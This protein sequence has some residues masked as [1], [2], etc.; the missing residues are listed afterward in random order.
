[1]TLTRSAYATPEHWE[2]CVSPDGKIY[3]RHRHL[4]ETPCC[5]YSSLCVKRKLTILTNND[6]RRSHRLDRI[7][8]AIDELLNSRLEAAADKIP[9]H[10]ELVLDVVLDPSA[11]QLNCGYYFVP[12]INGSEPARFVFWAEEMPMKFIVGPRFRH[13]VLSMSQLGEYGRGVLP[14]LSVD[15]LLLRCGPRDALL[16]WSTIRFG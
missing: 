5:P 8:R 12:P 14:N 15:H 6:V 1:M 10:S 11:Q 3:F 9:E 2:K 7:T 13:P 4:D 16:V